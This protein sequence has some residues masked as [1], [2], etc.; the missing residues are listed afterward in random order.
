[1]QEQKRGGNHAEH[2]SKFDRVALPTT[3]PRI[4]RFCCQVLD[5]QDKYHSAQKKVNQLTR[6]LQLRTNKPEHHRRC[7]EI[8]KEL[9]QKVDDAV[10]KQKDYERENTRLQKMENR[11]T[12]TRIERAFTA[13]TV[14]GDTSVGSNA[15]NVSESFD[16]SARAKLPIKLSTK[17]KIRQMQAMLQQLE[18]EVAERSDNASEINDWEDSDDSIEKKPNADETNDNRPAGDNPNSERQPLPA[19]VSEVP[20]QNEAKIT[21]A[22]AKLAKELMKLANTY[23][24]PELTFFDQAGRRRFGYQ[25]WLNRLRPILA[26]FSETSEVIQGE[27]IIP[28]K[29]ANCAG[30]KALYLVIGSRVDAYFQRAIRKL[31]GKGDQA[32]LLI[33]N[34]CAS[35]TADDMH[36]F[37]HL[38]TS[39]R[40]K[41]NE[42][43]NNF[44]RRFTFARTEAEGV[45]NVYS[46]QS[47]VNFA[48]AGLGSSK[49]PKYD[50]AVQLYNLERDSGKIFTLEHLEKNFFALDEK[51]SREAAKIR[52]AQGNTAQGQRGDRAYRNRGGRGNRN[53]RRNGPNKTADANAAIDTKYAHLTCYNC[54][55]KGHIVPNCPEK[56]SG[57]LSRPGSSHRTA[58][59]NAAQA[60]ADDAGNSPE[61]V[62]LARHVNIPFIR[63]P[64]TGPAAAITMD[65]H[66]REILSTNVYVS[67]VIRV[68]K[69]VFSWEKERSHEWGHLPD[70]Y[71]GNLEPMEDGL[72]VLLHNRPFHD[73]EPRFACVT[74]PDHRARII[75][76][77][78]L[79]PGL[80][81]CFNTAPETRP[82][83]FR[84]WH[85]LVKACIEYRLENIEQGLNLPVTVGVCNYTIIVTF[86][87]VGHHRPE[88]ISMGHLEYLTHPT[89]SD[90][91]W[92]Q[93]LTAISKSE[94]A[95]PARKKDP[96]VAEIGDPSNLNNYLPDS[97]ATQHVT[98]R[99]ADLV[100]AVEGKNLG[101]E[102]AD[103]HVI[104]CTTTGKIKVK[105][106]DDNGDQLEVILTD[107]MY[108]PGLATIFCRQ[109]RSSWLSCHDKEERH[110]PVLP[111]QWK[112]IPRYV[113]KFGRM[114]G[115]RC[116]SEDT[117]PKRGQQSY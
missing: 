78:G 2:Q 5:L 99:L 109:V 70:M 112:G 96:T 111:P 69:S 66:A 13:T 17:E 51:T 72:W 64:R 4:E 92:E 50:T 53:S 82:K 95:N 45:G 88:L 105:M 71:T 59:G 83:C 67:L 38:F 80:K 27:K 108:V 29:D 62:C 42:S 40:I 54:G 43:A 20:D 12:F 102:V 24:V 36:H 37:H 60:T 58:Q 73:L 107:M 49:S 85:L 84:Y 89:D 34:Q 35:T 3:S 91:E 79:V 14:L 93:A 7:Q 115:S 81:R 16:Q 116:R 74:Y 86:Y 18:H 101:V 75:F 65:F 19:P 57:K 6:E 41:E 103:G 104:K 68:D 55:K 113:A 100:D 63:P 48:L 94:T 98:P 97:G 30:N 39:I 87:P 61:L 22:Q 15:N 9:C 32:L 11:R 31:E 25:T 44:F 10:W 26:M 8:R 28:F 110:H 106:L 1:M 52:I 117:K 114:K 23:K 90:E 33:K 76:T 21:S 77:E 56:K 47:L 46:E